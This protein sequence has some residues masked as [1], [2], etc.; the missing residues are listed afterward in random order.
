MVHMLSV[1]VQSATTRWTLHDLGSVG[2][3]GRP[4][5]RACAAMVALLRSGFLEATVD[6]RAKQLHARRPCRPVCDICQD[7]AL[8]YAMWAVRKLQRHL[9]D[10]APLTR[11]E[12]VRD[13]QT[14]IDHVC[15]PAAADVTIEELRAALN[16]RLPEDDPLLPLVHAVRTQLLVPRGV[17]AKQAR[18]PRTA[19][20]AVMDARRAVVALQQG[21]SVRPDRDAKSGRRFAGLR[22]AHPRGFEVLLQLLRLLDYGEPEPYDKLA[23]WKDARP[24]DLVQLRAMIGGMLDDDWLRDWFMREV[25][26]R[27]VYNQDQARGRSWLVGAD[28]A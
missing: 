18:G 7:V 23:E 20:E 4:G 8:N 10:G 27:Q 19:K 11:G 17:G 9:R 12:V 6:E 16:R 14:I 24:G 13:W 3:D 1:P 22:A 15:G 21:W 26:G 2:S 25:D 5:D 28:R